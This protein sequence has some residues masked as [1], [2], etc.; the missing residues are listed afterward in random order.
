MT[1]WVE[2]LNTVTFHVFADGSDSDHAYKDQGAKMIPQ[3]QF[4]R[5]YNIAYEQQLHTMH[6]PNTLSLLLWCL[7]DMEQDLAQLS[8]SFPLEEITLQKCV[9]LHQML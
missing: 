8:H 3:T 1:E 7:H 6:F 5:I 4:E 2:K 9:F